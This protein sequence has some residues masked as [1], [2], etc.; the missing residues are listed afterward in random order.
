MPPTDTILPARPQDTTRHALELI[1]FGL[2]LAYVLL[3]ADSAIHR[4][5]LIDDAGRAIAND[6]VNVWAAGKLALAGPARR[7][8]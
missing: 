8:L 2:T 3:L 7:R 6:F 5:W 4:Y 1:G